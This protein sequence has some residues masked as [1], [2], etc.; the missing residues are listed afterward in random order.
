MITCGPRNSGT[1]EF[2]CSYGRRIAIG[3]ASAAGSGIRGYPPSE[4]SPNDGDSIR[5]EY[6][7]SC[8]EPPLRRIAR[9]GLQEH[10]RGGLDDARVGSQQRPF[11][12]EGTVVFVP[13][14]PEIDPDGTTGVQS[15]VRICGF[16]R[17][18]GVLVR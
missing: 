14:N 6:R 3:R 11:A 16:A 9:P 13:V 2:V 18:R 17:S 5:R 4:A 12:G 7:P 1:L 15:M 10:S 8:L